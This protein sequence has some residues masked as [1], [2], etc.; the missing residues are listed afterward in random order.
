[1]FMETTKLNNQNRPKKGTKKNYIHLALLTILN[2][3]VMYTEAGERGARP[4]HHVVEDSL[5]GAYQ[6][7][8]FP[9]RRRSRLS[10]RRL[11]VT[12]PFWPKAEQIGQPCECSRSGGGRGAVEEEGAPCGKSYRRRSSAC[13]WEQRRRQGSNAD[14]GEPADDGGRKPYRPRSMR[15]IATRAGQGMRITFGFFLFL[16]PSA[17]PSSGWHFAVI[18]M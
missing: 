12:F 3:Q 11:A 1:M 5:G 10:G 2:G 13:G 6:A 18:S 7:I 9:G 17:C 8:S 16:S 4:C 15:G 14:G